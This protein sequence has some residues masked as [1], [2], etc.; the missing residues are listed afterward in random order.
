MSKNKIESRSEFIG[1][2][3]AICDQSNRM[4]LAVNDGIE[5]RST[6]FTYADIQKFSYL[7]QRTPCEWWIKPIDDKMIMLR[8]RL[9][10]S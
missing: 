6:F 2:V 3:G 8:V 5:V 10:V 4:Y 9:F 7:L 1:R